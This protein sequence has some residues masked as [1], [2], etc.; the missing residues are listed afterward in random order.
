MV[1]LPP[2]PRFILRH[3]HYIAFP[4]TVAFLTI[5]IANWLLGVTVPTW[6]AAILSIISYPAILFSY[7]ALEER[8]W[9]RSAAAH[10]ATL[11]PIVKKTDFNVVGDVE[12]RFPRDMLFRVCE[13]YGNTFLLEIFFVKRF[14]TSEPEHVKAILATD[15]GSFEKGPGFRD[16]MKS[17]LGVGV[18][19]A[20]GEMW[21]FHRSMARP[22]F[23]KDRISHF[24][25]FDR[26]ALDALQ[27]MKTRLNEG[28]AV[29]WQDLVSRF[30]M[31]SATE[32]LF[33]KDVR[34][35]AAGLPYPPTSDIARMQTYKP[36]ADEFSSTFLEAQIASSKRGR[37]QQAW[38]LNEFWKD[39]VESRKAAID[40]FINPIL[41]DALRKNAE[42]GQ[43]VDSKVSEEDTLLSQL[44][45]VTDDYNVI[46]DETLNI[47]LAGRDTTACTL[48]FAV[49]RLAEHPDVLRRLREEI[50]EV[51]GPNRRPSYDDIRN[52][53]YLRAVIN[54]TLRLYP[55]VMI[56]SVF[57][58]HRRKDLWG[59]DAL[60]FDPDRFLDERV[61]KYLTPNPFIFLPFNAGPRICLGQQFAYNETSF[62]L[63]RLLQQFSAI[64]FVPEVAPESMVPPGYADSPGSD[65]SDRVWMGN[66][67]TLYAKGGL[68]VRMSEAQEE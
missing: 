12:N 29:D 22:F 61:Q 42:K 51:V 53:K 65:G 60:K 66:H 25:I 34:S 54:E 26:H 45:K 14:F 4:P 3:L 9:R 62:M 6:V 23:S 1:A 11:P 2:G 37:Y 31:D 21:K 44:L 8:R 41:T 57:M 20:D 46:H 64:E 30:T 16:Q 18:F 7:I 27:Q 32:F 67:L 24:D 33:G 13:K 48:T 5:N 63:I 49:Y 19:N 55:P 52:M 15:F 43:D 68:W 39:K 47:L 17:L 10:G 38:G 50:L 58:M 40:K 59:A 36:E 35:L 56:Y 28:Y